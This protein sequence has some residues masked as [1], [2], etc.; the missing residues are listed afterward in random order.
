MTVI[1]DIAPLPR[2]PGHNRIRAQY[3]L[4]SVVA[5]ERAAAVIAGEQSSGTF[6][7]LAQETAELHERVGAR[8][9][10][11]TPLADTTAPSL[12]VAGKAEGSARRALIEISWGLDNFG[13]SLPNLLATVAG[14]L[15]E[16]KEVTG[17]KLLDIDLPDAFAD[18]YLPPQFGVAGTLRLTGLSKGPLVGT[19]SRFL[20]SP[21]P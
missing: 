15:F 6:T 14:N 5:P 21:H 20:F 12:P 7:K 17:L 13:P 2:Q 19:I 8:V 9:E 10:S 16:L 1:T 18:R 3:L 11:I 4:E